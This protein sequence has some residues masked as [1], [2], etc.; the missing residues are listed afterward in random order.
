MRELI[1]VYGLVASV[2]L[3]VGAGCSG[4]SSDPGSAGAGGSE[5]AGGSGGMV[6]EATGGVASGGLPPGGT[7]TGGA[8]TGGATMGGVT[9][10]GVTT[11][12]V[13]TGGA[14]TGGVVTGGVTTGGVTTG[15]VTTGGAVTGGAVTGGA[16]TGGVTTG[17]V[18]TG[19]VTTGGAATGGAVTG[20][21]TTGG[22]VTG[23][24]AMG[25]EATGGASSGGAGASSHTGPWRITPFGDS[26]TG[27]TCYPKLLSKLLVDQGRDDFE[28]VGS[29]LNNQDCG[30]GVPNVQT[31]GHGG[32]LATQLVP[33]GAHASELPIW[34]SA[35]R[36]DIVLLHYGT[37][38]TWNSTISTQSILDAFS[39]ILDA[40]RAANPE[41]IVLV[42]QI[43]PNAACGTCGTSIPELNAAIAG[44]AA[45]EGTAASPIYVV[46]QYTGFDPATDTGD[47]CHPNL[48]GSQKMAERWAEALAAHGLL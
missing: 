40:L 31:E 25:G 22:A 24:V 9:T 1:V 38:D 39:V 47:G 3:G 26:I 21:V 11:G 6:G 5:A 45:T 10:G 8:A 4:G 41:V 12:G 2:L 7:A 30:S 23:G 14:V 15:G 44:W 16:V 28:F 20:G 18:T 36:S 13:T 48:V 46:D 32:Y 17:G 19:G 33:G 34:C 43:I 37:N 35:N 29:V 42:A 27:T